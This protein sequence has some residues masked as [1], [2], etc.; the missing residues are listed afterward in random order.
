MHSTPVQR[1]TRHGA[2]DWNKQDQ[3]HQG[4]ESHALWL[5]MRYQPGQMRLEVGG[6][7]T[8]HVPVQV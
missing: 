5:R 6:L 1:R 4:K 3:N 2:G 7:E 8:R